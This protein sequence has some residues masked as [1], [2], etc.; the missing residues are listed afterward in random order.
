MRGG[1]S[2]GR[3]GG[4]GRGRTNRPVPSKEELDMELDQY[5]ANTKSHLDK[6]ID[7]YMNQA[8]TSENWD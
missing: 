3:R 4:V 5:M 2:G 1:R 7:S 8:N 6:E